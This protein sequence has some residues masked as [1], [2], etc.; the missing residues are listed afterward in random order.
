MSSADD[1]PFTGH[2]QVLIRLAVGQAA[3][4]AEDVVRHSGFLAVYPNAAGAMWWEQKPTAM[5]DQL[6]L[7]ILRSYNVDTNRIYLAGFSNGGSAAL[8]FGTLWP[9]RW[10][11]IA[12][13]MGAGVNSP[14]GEEFPA[15]ERPSQH[16]IAVSAR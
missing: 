7:E 2:P 9:G 11:A 1:E 13:Q 6:L 8:Y 16:S 15:A 12:S 5:V 10:A 14:S 3:L 4:T